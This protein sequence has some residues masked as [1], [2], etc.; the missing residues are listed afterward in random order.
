[1]VKE[2]RKY[3]GLTW[4]RQDEQGKGEVAT[5]KMTFSALAE[6]KCV[7]IHDRKRQRSRVI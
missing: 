6:K 3:L 2:G 7:G 5:E 1:M 4:P